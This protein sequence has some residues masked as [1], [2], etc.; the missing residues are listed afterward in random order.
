[1]NLTA[2]LALIW[3]KTRRVSEY[4]PRR[5]LRGACIFW[6]SHNCPDC[7]LNSE[8][9][10]AF[11]A[12]SCL[13]TLLP[14]GAT[15]HTQDIRELQ[16][17][18]A[19]YKDK[20]LGCDTLLYTPCYEDINLSCTDMTMQCFLLEMEVMLFEMELFDADHNI[21]ARKNDSLLRQLPQNRCKL[22]EMHDMNNCT[23]FLEKFEDFLQIIL[24]QIHS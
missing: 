22:C 1:H 19:S 17:W 4:L 7:L 16:T 8:V 24:D 9:W 5:S 14:V 10:I 11:F 2:E 13:S 23:V 12:L 15:S 21:Q 6:C 20:L 3:H 18:I